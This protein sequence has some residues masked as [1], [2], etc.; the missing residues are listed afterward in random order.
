M[1]RIKLITIKRQLQ[2]KM[3]Y[4]LEH[5][6]KGDGV[7]TLDEAFEILL[8]GWARKVKR[9]GSKTF[10]FYLTNTIVKRGWMSEKHADDFTEYCI[11]GWRII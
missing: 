3:H 1:E 5:A 8:F 2:N 4:P 9:Q 11:P 10:D 7:P 6:R